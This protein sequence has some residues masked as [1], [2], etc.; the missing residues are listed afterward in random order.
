MIPKDSEKI[1]KAQQFNVTLCR[2]NIILVCWFWKY[3]KEIKG[4]NLP[5]PFLPH[6]LKKEIKKIIKLKN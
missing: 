1:R 3:Y 6:P 5:P 2:M 4:E